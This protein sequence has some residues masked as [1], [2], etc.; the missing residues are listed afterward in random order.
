MWASAGIWRGALAPEMPSVADWAFGIVVNIAGILMFCWPVERWL[1]ARNLRPMV[2]VFLIIGGGA[3]GGFL[4]AA[5]F[6]LGSPAVGLFGIAPGATTAIV[7]V[8]SN[9]DLFRMKRE[10]Q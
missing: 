7:W 8:L 9:L 2:R 10:Y 5:A 3:L 6:A 1:A 4:I